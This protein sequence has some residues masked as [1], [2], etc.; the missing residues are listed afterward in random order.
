MAEYFRNI[1]VG[2]KVLSS[3]MRGGMPMFEDVTCPHLRAELTC[4]MEE[5]HRWVLVIRGR[6]GDIFSSETKGNRRFLIDVQF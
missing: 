3:L 2:G 5:D 6:N 4:S 1:S